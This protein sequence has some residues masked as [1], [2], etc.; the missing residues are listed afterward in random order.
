MFH[1][2]VFATNDIRRI[3]TPVQYLRDRNA[4]SVLHYER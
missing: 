4:G 1:E 2:V 3:V